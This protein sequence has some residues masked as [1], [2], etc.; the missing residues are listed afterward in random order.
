MSDHIGARATQNKTAGKNIAEDANAADK[1][2]AQPAHPAASIEQMNSG[3]PS[4]VTPRHIL[5]LQ[6]SLGNQAVQRLIQRSTNG[7]SAPSLDADFPDRLRSAGTGHPLDAGVQRSLE[8]NVGAP[9]SNVRLH[10]DAEADELTRAVDARAF[11]SGGDIFF[12]SGAYDPGSSSGMRLLTHEAVHVVQQAAGPVAGSPVAEG[13]RLS[14]PADPYER[15]AESIAMRATPA[16][17]NSLAAAAP[18]F[19]PPET[20]QR[21]VAP[22]RSIQRDKEEK[23]PPQPDPES[24]KNP[25]EAPVVKVEIEKLVVQQLRE[26][27]GTLVTQRYAGYLNAVDTAM[28]ELEK[29]KKEQEEKD[30]F[31]IN[32]VLSI[33]L[34]AAGPAMAGLANQITGPKLLTRVKDGVSS[35]SSRL[36]KLANVSEAQAAK[37]LENAGDIYQ[38][39]AA[40]RLKEL[41]E[42]FDVDKAKG[43]VEKAADKLKDKTVELAVINDKWACGA[44]Y[45][46]A[47]KDSADSSSIDLLHSLQGMSSYDELLGV[48]NAF[49]EM[50]LSKFREQVKVQAHNFMAQVAPL[51]AEK[52]ANKTGHGAKGYTLVRVDAWGQPRLALAI[53]SPTSANYLFQSWITPDMEKT[54]LATY[55]TPMDVRGAAFDRLPN[56][57]QQK[58]TERIVKT[59]AWGKMRLVVV[60]VKDNAIFTTELYY[61]FVRWVPEKER[62]DMEARAQGTQIGGLMT[63]APSDIKNLKA[64][65]D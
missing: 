21:S 43:A 34:L 62:G 40:D 65:V 11:T 48:Y 31:W 60:Q 4:A 32:A 57:V 25:F 49:N 58:G 36:M 23:K 33:G 56:P 17:S 28:R 9:L 6:T 46:E 42:R 16:P 2:S 8:D 37:L 22:T 64:P 54:A 3:T 53:Y 19:G 52:A 29:E 18:Q 10:T 38:K 41:A 35:N 1:R 15:A 59:D 61:D 5:A 44:A 24:L 45:L 12:R 27:T 47:L 63:L 50:S 39:V 7:S 55:G 30:K 13:I 14:D 51:L 20:I 26:L